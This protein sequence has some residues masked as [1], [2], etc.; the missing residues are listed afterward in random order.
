LEFAICLW[1]PDTSPEALDELTRAGVTAIEPG[2]SF[3]LQDDEREFEA[4]CG[5]VREAGIRLYS[6]HAPFGGDDDLSNP[7]AAKRA[8]AVE[9]HARAVARAAVAG[10]SCIV[11]HPGVGSKPEERAHRAA[12]FLSSIEALLDYAAEHGVT[13]AVENMLPGHVGSE[14]GE[15]LEA[16]R[17]FDSPR[18]GV[19][20]DTGH[21]HLAGEGVMPSFAAL[22]EHVVTFHLQDND[23]VNDRHLQPPYGTIDWPPFARELGRMEIGYPLAVEAPPWARRGARLEPPAPWRQF[24]R[25]LEA[26]FTTGVVT[27]ELDGA[28]ARLVCDRCG[29]Y[30]FGTREDWFCACEG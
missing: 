13:L 29:H 23:G 3:L 6:C 8:G 28:R 17:R 7:D 12:A 5:R 16:F 1:R 11:V 4:G 2:P 21:A 14:S 26:L 19:C 24:L 18:L 15:I 25:E 9:S 27:A 10:A 22:R 30:R 20:F